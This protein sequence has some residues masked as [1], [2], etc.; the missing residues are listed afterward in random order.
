MR[1]YFE[2]DVLP[3]QEVATRLKETVELSCQNVPED[4]LQCIVNVHAA[5][6]TYDDDRDSF[7]K[8]AAMILWA[9]ND[10]LDD[11]FVACSYNNLYLALG[12]RE[13]MQLTF[14]KNLHWYNAIKEDVRKCLIL[15]SKE[16]SCPPNS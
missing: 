9:L 13:T 6:T 14:R 16:S 4:L 11:E 15:L 1:Q 5:A 7:E 8:S 3:A 12:L 10:L 2:D